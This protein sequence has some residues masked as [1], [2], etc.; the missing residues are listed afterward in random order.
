MADPDWADLRSRHPRL[1]VDEL[2]SAYQRGS[3]SFTATELAA[4]ASTVDVTFQPGQALALLADA[5]WLIEHWRDGERDPDFPDEEPEQIPVFVWNAGPRRTP[6]WLLLVHGMNTK[7]LWQEHLTFDIGL[8]QGQAIPTFVFKYG[9]IVPGVILPWRRRTLKRRLRETILE[10]SEQAP[11]HSVRSEPDVVAHSFGTWLLGHVLLDEEADPKGLRIGR[12]ILT[13]CIL[14]PDFPWKRLQTKG[15]V[16]EVLNHYGTADSVVPWAQWTIT[17][18]GPSGRSGFNAAPDAV[19][20][21]INVIAPEFTHSEAL[22]DRQRFTSY[23]KTW[24]PF[25]TSPVDQPFRGLVD[26]RRNSAWRP[27]HW[28]L[29]NGVVPLVGV[30]A[31]VAMVWLVLR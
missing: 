31:V 7:G 18:S 12:V 14:R 24:R 25:M 19:A 3:I 13:G 22:S 27:V 8:W 15:L 6:G 30:L 29:H 16:G 10:L 26:T 20:N 9:R 5:T 2:E 11:K 17:D 1:L 4:A 28:P 23:S 21:L